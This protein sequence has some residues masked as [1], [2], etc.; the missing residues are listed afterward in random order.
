[1]TALDVVGRGEVSDRAVF[2]PHCRGLRG[3][4]VSAG[5]LHRK[6]GDLLDGAAEILHD[7][8]GMGIECLEMVVNGV[9][10][11]EFADPQRHITE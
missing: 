9:E 10:G 7:V 6:G 4:N 5:C 3:V 8:H 1:M 11:H 2:K